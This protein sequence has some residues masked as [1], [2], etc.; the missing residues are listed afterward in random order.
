MSVPVPYLELVLVLGFGDCCGRWLMA[1]DVVCI[2]V[3]TG[4]GVE[5][6]YVAVVVLEEFIYA[7]GY[8]EGCC[9]CPLLKL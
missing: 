9:M 7:S 8:P 6:K 5:S 1:E 3:D 2:V 4:L